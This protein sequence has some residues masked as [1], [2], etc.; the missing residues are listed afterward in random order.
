M[1]TFWEP[2]GALWIFI[3]HV[4]N[5]NNIV[6]IMLFNSVMFHL[7]KVDVVGG[8][9]APTSAGTRASVLFLT[10][11]GFLLKRVTEEPSGVPASRLLLKHFQDIFN[12]TLISLFKQPKKITGSSWS[13]GFFVWVRT[14]SRSDKAFLHSA[15]LTQIGL[16]VLHY[17]PTYITPLL[18]YWWWWC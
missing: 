18:H 13:C 3:A 2:A 6:W 7:V 4:V 11:W 10:T 9:G 16:I 14:R 5:L 17:W 1:D 12:K 15:A 8:G